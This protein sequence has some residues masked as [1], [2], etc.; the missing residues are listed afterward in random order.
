MANAN[1]ERSFNSWT[2]N[3]TI[4]SW[5]REQEALRRAEESAVVASLAVGT[6]SELIPIPEAA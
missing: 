5:K 4:E 2:D 6:S 3:P 1:N